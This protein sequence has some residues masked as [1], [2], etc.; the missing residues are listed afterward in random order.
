MSVKVGAGVKPTSS[1]FRGEEPSPLYL[2]TDGKCVLRSQREPDRVS[3]SDS[4]LFGIR[5]PPSPLLMCFRLPVDAEV[6]DS[7]H[8]RV[9]YVLSYI[10]GYENVEFI[11]WAQ[12]KMNSN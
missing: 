5:C 10:H 12:Q 1:V 4:V 2:R 9:G 3:F 6:R 11:D 8:L 7:G